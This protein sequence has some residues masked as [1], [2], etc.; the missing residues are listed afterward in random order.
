MQYLTGNDAFFHATIILLL[1]LRTENHWSCAFFLVLLFVESR[2]SP[3]TT[4]QQTI[5]RNAIPMNMKANAGKNSDVICS[6]QPM[7]G[8]HTV[9]QS[10]LA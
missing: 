10:S 6:M 2:N 7:H 9:D 8:M 4:S 3:N 5:R 1:L